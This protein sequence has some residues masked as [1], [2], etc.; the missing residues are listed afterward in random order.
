MVNPTGNLTLNG[1]TDAELAHIL[2]VKAKNANVF[3]FNPQTLQPAP[4]VQQQTY[5]NNAS[6]TW[7]TEQGLNLVHGI[8]TFLLKKE[9]TAKAQGQ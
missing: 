6:F 3:H 1:I 7:N 9:E 8:V 4:N 2:E 5:Y